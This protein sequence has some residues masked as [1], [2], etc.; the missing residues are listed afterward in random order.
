MHENEQL[1]TMSRAA[2]KIRD[3]ARLRRKRVGGLAIS[4]VAGIGLLLGTVGSAS[5]TPSAGDWLKL[6]TC[7]SGGNYATNTGNGY[8]GAYQFDLGTWASVGGTGLPSNA[9]PATQDALAYRLWQ[10]RGW[11]PWTCAAI[12]GL[13][14]GGSGGPVIQVQAV[15][16][17]TVVPSVGSFDSVVVSTGRTGLRI[18]GWALD[19]SSSSASISVRVTVNGAA[20]TV[21]AASAR[22]DVNRRLTVSGRHGFSLPVAVHAGPYRICATALG[23][24]PGANTALGCK[25]VTVERLPGGHLDAVRVSQSRV[26]VQGWAYDPAVPGR[27]IQAHIYVNGVGYSVP[28]SHTRRDVNAAHIPGNHGFTA[29]LPLR[30]GANTVCAIA[31]STGGA[32]ASLGCRTVNLA[33]PVGVLDKVTVKAGKASIAGW[34]FDPNA[35]TTSIRAHVFV[36]NIG[37]SLPTSVARADV[38][39]SQKLSGTHGFAMT[40]TLRSGANRV[41]AIAIGVGAGNNTNL[42]CATVRG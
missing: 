11:S 41:C 5:A 21:P 12:V 4:A 17:A 39:R 30:T 20:Y 27:V 14:Q 15:H 38:N 28:A 32:H 2:E 25:T 31:S 22:P 24:S 18:S 19:R 35:R 34:A 40:A 33:A 29:V 13:P 1:S 6:R 26:V 16:R 3:R 8:Y 23:R 9:S 36:N 42:G 10:Q 37:A 7:E